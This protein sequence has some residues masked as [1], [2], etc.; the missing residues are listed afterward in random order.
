MKKILRIV[1]GVAILAVVLI[2]GIVM[3]ME[4]GKNSDNK[5]Q[6]TE[7]VEKT[8]K[9]SKKNDA[10]SK[11]STKK[12]N[13]SDKVKTDDQKSE[14]KKKYLDVPY[15]CTYQESTY[16]LLLKS[17]GE[18]IYNFKDVNDASNLKRIKLEKGTYEINSGGLIR[19]GKVISSL[20]AGWGRAEDIWST[21]PVEV[22]FIGRGSRYVANDR[23]YNNYD[24]TVINDGEE[25][26]GHSDGIDLMPQEGLEVKDPEKVGPS[27]Q[28]QYTDSKDY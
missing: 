1:G 11:T 25:I 13:E 7:H 15:T 3:G 20:S 28:K 17:N 10:P 6:A 4:H 18:Y 24:F 26:Q 22:H 14:E 23:A 21:T 2:A 5:Q 8:K 9:V 12:E 16:T 19:Y 27:L